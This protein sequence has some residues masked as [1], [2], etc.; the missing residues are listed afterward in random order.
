MSGL[1]A[2]QIV[3]ATDFSESAARAQ[4]YAVFVAR[5]YDAKL[6]V[7]HVVESPLAFGPD[8]AMALYLQHAQMETDQHF[9][10][11]EMQLRETEQLSLLEL[12]HLKG[13]PSEQIDQFAQE[14]AADL[15]VVG[16]RGRSRLETILLGSTAE[17]VIK[18][19][20]CPVFAVPA[21]GTPRYEREQASRAKPSIQHILT[22]LDFSSPSL[23]A[24]EYA[25]QV[26]RQFS[27]RMTL[28]HV[29]EPMYYE[30][31]VGL[32]SM[33]LLGS[34]EVSRQSAEQRWQQWV[35]WRA[36]FERLTEL[37]ESIGIPASSIV[38]GGVPANSIVKCAKEQGCDLIIMGTHGRR[39]LS[40]LRFGSVAEG[41]LRESACPV[42]TVKSPKFAAGHRRVIP[43]EI[44]EEKTL[45]P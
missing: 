17:R 3:F 29:L 12:R 35:H 20:P 34:A 14:V 36:Q 23:D 44:G 6:W 2:R 25:I 43:E 7:I 8:A 16:T 32:R 15:I 37:V 5:T 41:V 21:I 13:M 39:G 22:A 42:L 10:A 4:D 30:G 31:E 33:D 9:L 40:R 19:A 45:L 38:G 24:L 27:A 18:A 1:A 11:I 28:L 26:A